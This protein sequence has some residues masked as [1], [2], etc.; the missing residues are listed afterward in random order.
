MLRDDLADTVSCGA[1]LR[2]PPA[3][4]CDGLTLDMDLRYGATT[5]MEHEPAPSQA[6][7]YGLA[8]PSTA[9]AVRA[10]AAAAAAAKAAD[11]ATAPRFASALLHPGWGGGG[12]GR[13]S[14]AMVPVAGEAGEEEPGSWAPAG[15]GQVKDEDDE[16]MRA[17]AEQHA[18]EVE[19]P[20]PG[21]PMLATPMP[22]AA[23]PLVPALL[24]PPPLDPGQGLS[25]PPGA[26]PRPPFD[27][28]GLL[29]PFQH[30]PRAGPLPPPGY[31]PPPPG[32]CP[33][34]PGFQHQQPPLGM[35]PGAQPPMPFLPHH[36]FPPLWPPGMPLPPPGA[37]LPPPFYPPLPP[38]PGFPGHCGAGATPQRPAPGGPACRA[39]SV[40]P[41]AV[42]PASMPC[43]GPVWGCEA[44]PS[45]PMPMPVGPPPHP[46]TLPACLFPLLRCAWLEPACLVLPQAA[47][48]SGSG[49]DC[50]SPFFAPAGTR[51]LQDPTRVAASLPSLAAGGSLG[52]PAGACG[53]GEQ[54]YSDASELEE[55]LN[56]GFSVAAVG[57]GGGIGLMAR[58]GRQPSDESVTG[59]GPAGLPPLWPGA[60][61]PPPVP[62]ELPQAPAALA[63]GAA[64]CCARAAR[65]ACLLR[66]RE[67]KARWSSGGKRIIRYQMRKINADKRPR[68]KGRFIK[69]GA[70]LA[71]CQHRGGRAWVG[72]V[73]GWRI[74]R[75]VVG[76][77]MLVGACWWGGHGLALA[78]WCGGVR[79]MGACA[80]PLRCT[81]LAAGPAAHVCGG[82]LP[83]ALGC[84]LRRLRRST[85]TLPTM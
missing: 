40:S 7:S 81:H 29:A 39:P 56:N 6:L 22:A 70:G 53:S 58:A 21:S 17:T 77:G 71:G 3:W 49:D 74:R 64:V 4:A 8:G 32:F 78:R 26:A 68:V 76:L 44:H 61:P 72:G 12:P 16:E 14:R 27:S 73:P 19:R 9:A 48:P 25:Q 82:P 18:V 35:P 20:P 24:L 28:A 59:M 60:P 45:F 42:G 63:L 80:A 15:G 47:A 30:Q 54:L 51:S 65:A 33:P 62:G 38:P 41:F 34:P 13:D 11:T 75:C 85:T 23:E 57:P 52:G 43:A 36:Q 10:S 5:F 1:S 79:V 37:M 84:R 50:D 31:F 2:E 66:Y 67:K 83:C 69:V 46:P 55:C